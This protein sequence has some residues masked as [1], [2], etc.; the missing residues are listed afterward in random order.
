MKTVSDNQV[1]FKFVEEL[2]LQCRFGKLANENL[3]SSVQGLDP[4]RAFLYL[5]ALLSHA[6]QA[7]RLLWPDRTE[8]KPRG[9]R[10]RSELKVTGDSPLRLRDLRHKLET[11]DEHFE[12]WLSGMESPNYMDFNIMPQGTMLGY[13]QDTFQRN[14][15]PDTYRLTFRGESCDLRPI[16]NEMHRLDSAAQTWLRT[17]NPW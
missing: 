7:S 9:E 1:M 6:A 14:L 10:L 8:S 3:R 15:D 13:K 4:E 11:S 2:R 5:H 12:D 17:H 16:V